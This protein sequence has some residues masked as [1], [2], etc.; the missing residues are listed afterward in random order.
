VNVHDEGFWNVHDEGTGQQPPGGIIAWQFEGFT[1]THFT[2]EHSPLW[3][4]LP[5]I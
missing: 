2:P 4:V 5:K 3:E 1:G